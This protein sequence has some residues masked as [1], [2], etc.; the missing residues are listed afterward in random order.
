MNS[1][2]ASI[3]VYLLLVSTQAMKDTPY[4]SS[5]SNQADD[6]VWNG[7]EEPNQDI[8]FVGV[9]PEDSK[10]SLQLLLNQDMPLPPSPRFSP[11]TDH[12][13]N[14]NILDCIVCSK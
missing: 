9:E 4:N 7:R 5:I 6:P 10:L 3:L 11:P 13:E 12:P 1:E 14:G 2:K 8:E